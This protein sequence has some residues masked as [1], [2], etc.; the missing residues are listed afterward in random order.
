MMKPLT[1]KLFL[2]ALVANGNS[3]AHIDIKYQ[4]T[5][6]SGNKGNYGLSV[7]SSA[8]FLEEL[9]PY[10]YQKAVEICGSKKYTA[11]VLIEKPRR[12]GDAITVTSVG[13]KCEVMPASIFGTLS[14][15]N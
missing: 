11:S 2:L 8:S 6:V 4:I 13:E 3:L 14:C 7:I 9:A 10:W 12:C 5:E 1:F 15:D